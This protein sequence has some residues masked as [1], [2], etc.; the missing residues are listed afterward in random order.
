[1]NMYIKINS[2]ISSLKR[3]QKSTAVITQE[4]EDFLMFRIISAILRHGCLEKP[5]M[6]LDGE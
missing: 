4:N 6:S 3:A 5:E 1:M 2:Y